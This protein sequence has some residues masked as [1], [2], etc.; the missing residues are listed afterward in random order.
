MRQVLQGGGNTAYGKNLNSAETTALG[1]NTRD[2]SILQG[3][4]SGAGRLLVRQEL[5]RGFDVSPHYGGLA[6]AMVG[7]LLRRSRTWIIT[8]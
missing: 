1:G 4:S 5:C 3:Q 2:G 7:V 6:C 8:S